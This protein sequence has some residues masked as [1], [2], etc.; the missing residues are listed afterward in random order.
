MNSDDSVRRLKGETRPINNL[1]KR[2]VV[3][4]GLRSVDWVVSFSEDTPERLIC[5][6][7]PNILVKGGD[8][9]PEQIAGGRCVIANGGEV[10]CLDF[11]KGLSTTSVVEKIK[12][13]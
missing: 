6:V 12:K 7:L 8:W 2:M 13:N 4:A 9:R 10:K 1:E 3:L 5:K 11:I